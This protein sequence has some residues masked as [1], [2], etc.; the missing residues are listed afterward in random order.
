MSAGSQGGAAV[1]AGNTLEK[2]VITAV[3]SKGFEVVP[4]KSWLTMPHACGEELLLTRVPYPSIYGHHSHA[5]F[6]LHSDRFGLDTT[7][8]ANGHSQ[9]AASTRSYRFCI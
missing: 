1:G 2:T 3:V 7:S 4:Y 6:L 5:D 9:Q 8:S